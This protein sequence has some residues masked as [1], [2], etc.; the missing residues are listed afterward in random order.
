VQVMTVEDD[1]PSA[2]VE[3]VSSRVINE[4]DGLIS[5]PQFLDDGTFMVHLA[6]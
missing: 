1:L 6:T 4:V 5:E 3:M 2:W